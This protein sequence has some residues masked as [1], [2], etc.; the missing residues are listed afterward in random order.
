MRV[1]LG[2]YPLEKGPEYPKRQH[3]THTPHQPEVGNIDPCFVVI[4]SRS[5]VVTLL[6]HSESS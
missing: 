3:A 1:P 5:E 2:D 6:G 4:N